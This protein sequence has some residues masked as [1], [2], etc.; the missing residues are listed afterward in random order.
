MTALAILGIVALLLLAPLV[1]A[2]LRQ[3]TLFSM[4]LRNIGRRRAEA[5]LVVAGALLGT[6]II[7]SSLVVGDVIEASFADV[8]RTQYG[9]VDITLTSEEGSLDEVATAVDAGEIRGIDGLLPVTTATATLEAPRGHVAVPQVQVV[10][11]DLAA[12]RTFG[13]DPAITGVA[14]AGDLVPGQIVINERTA[15]ELDVVAGDELRLHAYD[16]SVDVSDHTRR[17]GSRA[18]GIRRRAG[19]S[20]NGHRVGRGLPPRWPHHPVSV[21]WCPS[22]EEC[23]TRVRCRMRSW[24]IFVPRSR[25]CRVSRSKRPRHWCSTT[26]TARVPG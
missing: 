15:G 7:T 12:A 10:E 19:R 25:G 21:S 9:P 4:A 6:A 14:D 16:S 2:A 1:V 20:R 13:A 5:V 23:S 11:L 22:T 18:R 26:R 8:A 3:R 24:R 17:A